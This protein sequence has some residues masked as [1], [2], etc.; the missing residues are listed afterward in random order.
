MLK[1]ISKLFAAPEKESPPD[2]VCFLVGDVV[3]L[4]HHCK[5]T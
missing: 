2:P 1:A 4:H 5:G 3:L